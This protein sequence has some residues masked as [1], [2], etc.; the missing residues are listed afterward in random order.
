MKKTKNLIAVIVLI[1][2]VLAACSGGLPQGF[3][4]EAGGRRTINIGF[5]GG[6]CQAPIALAH[7][8]GFFEEEGLDTN[9]RLT[10]DLVTSRDLLAAGQ[11]DVAGGM[12]A[13]WFVPIIAG[14]DARIT[15]GLHTGCASAFVLAD[16]SVQYFEPGHTVFASGAAGSAFHNIARRFVYRQGLTDN[17]IT[18][19]SG[20]ADA[21]TAR[22]LDGGADIIVIPDQV[23]QRFVDDGRFRRIRSLED[24]DFMSEACCVIVMMGSFMQNNPITAKR[25]TR[26]IYR[27]ARF[28]GESEANKTAAVELLIEHGLFAGPY[29]IVEYTVGLM[30][31]WQWGLTHSETET[32]LDTS[33]L[34]FRALGLIGDNIDL[35]LLKNHIWR[36]QDVSGITDFVPSYIVSGPSTPTPNVTIACCG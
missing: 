24:D 18:W 30:S 25:I 14:V 15:L 5:E 11:I 16:S 23:G 3:D 9:L 29:G 20:A 2:M 6:I 22:L 10:G 21:A 12:L 34:E 8:M 32:T 31:R 26:A 19:L 17:D 1:V 33:I 4:E 36:P 35:E 13:G 27:A 7:L 28:V